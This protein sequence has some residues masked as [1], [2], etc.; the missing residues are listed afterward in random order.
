MFCDSRSSSTKAQSQEICPTKSDLP[1]RLGKLKDAL[2]DTN[3]AGADAVSVQN[4]RS[5][6]H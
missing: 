2:G 1:E 6:W 3:I 4:I 5:T